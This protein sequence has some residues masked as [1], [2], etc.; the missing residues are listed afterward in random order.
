[1]VV[2]TDV[3]EKWEATDATRG[4]FFVLQSSTPYHQALLARYL[5]RQPEKLRALTRGA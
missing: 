2:A 1:M 4:R 5:L 3:N